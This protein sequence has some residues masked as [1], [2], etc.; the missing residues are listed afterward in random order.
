MV[1]AL[2]AWYSFVMFFV[3]QYALPYWKKHTSEFDV[4]QSS[5]V[6]FVFSYLRCL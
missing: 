5:L 3:V 4:A 6:V 2:E 1:V